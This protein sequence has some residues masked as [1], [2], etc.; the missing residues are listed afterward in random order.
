MEVYYLNKT[1]NDFGI[2]TSYSKLIL[3]GEHSVVYGKPAI[4]LPFP[5]IEAKSEVFG[6]NGPIM[7]E[8][9]YYSGLLSEIP[10]MLIG[11]SACILETCK[12]L[13]KPQEGFLIRISSSIPIGRGLG[14]SA[15][16]AIAIVRS[17]F[18]FYKLPIDEKLLMHLVHNAEKY[19]HGNPSGIDMFA[20]SSEHPIWFQKKKPIIPLHIQDPFYVVVGDSGR[21]G[22]TRT[23][24][25]SIR[26]KYIA[27]PSRTENFINL[28]ELY[29]YKAKEAL[30]IGDATTLGE[31]MNLAQ[32]ELVLLGVSDQGIDYLVDVALQEGAL[33]AKL[34][35]GGRGGCIIALANSIEHARIVSKQLKKAGANQTWYFQIGL[36]RGE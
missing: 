3:I 12:V 36:D 15:A 32:K 33:G 20:A 21:V 35:G 19:A 4:A 1:S 22:D 34:T 10:D 24:V 28:L 6:M 31:M 29:T 5:T 17:L 7:M 11:I 9:P 30:L 26:K 14:S 8:S 2:G 13:N 25:E 23:A 27:E 16:L 18:S